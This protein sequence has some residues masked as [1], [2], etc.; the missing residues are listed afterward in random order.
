[1]T[2]KT[3]FVVVRK[4]P[5]YP[6]QEIMD[7]IAACGDH[8]IKGYASQTGDANTAVVT[9]HPYGRQGAAAHCHHRLGGRHIVVE[10]GYVRKDAL[11][12][13]QYCVEF[14]GF[15]GQGWIPKHGHD[16]WKWHRLG[17]EL[18]PWRQRGDH[19]LVC[20]QRGGDYSDYSMPMDWPDSILDRLPHLTDR[21][22]KYRPHP[23]RP[24][25][26]TLRKGVEITDPR[27]P[28]HAD[29]EGAH[30]CVVWCSNAATEAIISGIPVF[31]Q[32]PNLKL[33]S[34]A[35]DDLT[36]IEDP[37]MEHRGRALTELSWSQWSLSD[38][39]RGE[40]WRFLMYSA[41]GRA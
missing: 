32:G 35:C 6:F 25:R 24:W 40:P 29:L 39:K 31:Y 27:R 3:G 8:A 36:L 4:R 22:I 34:I 41:E 21:P 14:D 2:G 18:R 26:P 19:I 9:W 30:A 38:L 12:E 28:I 20:G 16:S 15:N 37:P 23:G 11:G 17:A 10:N 33:A 7:G 13:A 1:M 5:E